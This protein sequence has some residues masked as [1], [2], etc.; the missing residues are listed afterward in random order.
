[1]KE[2]YDTLKDIDKCMSLT[3]DVMFKKMSAKKEIKSFE[4]DKLGLY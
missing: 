2:K 3:H 1:M 4:N